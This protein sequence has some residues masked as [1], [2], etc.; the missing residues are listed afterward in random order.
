ML[1]LQAIPA[2]EKQVGFVKGVAGSSVCPTPEPYLSLTVL[3]GVE[4]RSLSTL[5]LRTKCLLWQF[6]QVPLIYLA[7]FIFSI[8]HPLIFHLTPALHLSTPY[9]RYWSLFLFTKDAGVHRAKSVLSLLMGK[10]A[11]QGALSS[12][13]VIHSKL[14]YT[15]SLIHALVFLNPILQHGHLFLRQNK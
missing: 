12:R 11:Y 2:Q 9:G 15:L 3:P 6:P 1:R 8:F 7:P 4:A 10:L 5:S 13:L 14:T